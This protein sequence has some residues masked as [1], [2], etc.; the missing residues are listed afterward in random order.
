MEKTD[1]KTETALVCL[2]K[3]PPP[4]GRIGRPVDWSLGGF[5]SLADSS[6]HVGAVGR[7]NDKGCTWRMATRKKTRG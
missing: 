6:N 3:L 4:C 1:V 2:G 7:E 5:G